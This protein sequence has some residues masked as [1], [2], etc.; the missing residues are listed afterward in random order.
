MLQVLVV[1]C[2]CQ[3]IAPARPPTA[4]PLIGQELD[5]LAPESTGW[6]K[7]AIAFRLRALRT[8]R[9]ARLDQ[10]LALTETQRTRLAAVM[11]E[12]VTK[13]F[14]GSAIQVGPLLRSERLR[15]ILTTRQWQTL[16]RW[17]KEG[18]L[19]WYARKAEG[20][21]A[22]IEADCREC[23]LLVVDRLAT[24]LRLTEPQ[25]RRLKVAAR[26]AGPRFRQQ[27]AQEYAALGELS[28]PLTTEFL[29]QDG[30]LVPLLD[31][32]PFWRTAIESTLTS[33]QQR[34]LQETNRRRLSFYREANAL[35]T[36][37]DLQ[38][39]LPL[40]HEETT[41]FFNLISE[42]FV[43]HRP[44]Y[45]LREPDHPVLGVTRD[46]LR[47]VLTEAHADEFLKL[48]SEAREQVRHRKRIDQP[49]DQP[50]K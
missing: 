48:M 14:G 20:G 45:P 11:R 7:E 37:A 33:Q 23:A 40:T 24:E 38:V 50:G 36:T 19:A 16:E 3:Q 10:L 22:R 49:P 8:A 12:D 4:R 34:Q 17:R 41:R 5:L 30:T 28:P 26:G 15:P 46:D 13:P 2:L 9:L 21:G 39:G 47:G 25:Q 42:R 35:G 32:V 27:F 6:K 31:E 18:T 29:L 1:A 43:L 44:V